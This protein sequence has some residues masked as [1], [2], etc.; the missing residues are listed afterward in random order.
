MPF[1]LTGAAFPRT[2]PR[3]NGQT[4]WR[5]AASASKE[6]RRFV[7]ARPPAGLLRFVRCESAARVRGRADLARK[8]S[9]LGAAA[10]DDVFSLPSPTAATQGG[11]ELGAL[12]QA[13]P[14]PPEGHGALW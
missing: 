13:A 10:V 5:S 1:R 3:K 8:G 2:A 7:F 6:Q 11:R 4:L 12:R 9:S 14:G